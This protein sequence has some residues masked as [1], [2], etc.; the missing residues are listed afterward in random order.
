MSS[1]LDALA[2]MCRHYPGGRPAIAARLGKTDETLRRELSVSD[3]GH[4]MG[5][6]DALAIVSMCMEAHTPDADA[7]AI[8]VAAESGGHYVGAGVPDDADCAAL[9][10]RLGAENK[11]AA[12]LTQVVLAALADGK[13]SDNERVRIER[14]AMDLM[15]SVTRLVQACRKNNSALRSDVQPCA[16]PSAGTAAA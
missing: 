12:D 2:R 7:L 3:Q 1:P 14:E 9:L 10:H 5:L 15:I 8:V 4:K 6:A 16:W 11:E 13:V